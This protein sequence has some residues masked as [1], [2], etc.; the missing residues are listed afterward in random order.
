MAAN[1]R[2]MQVYAELAELEHRRG[3]LQ[4]RDRF[5]ILAADAALTDGRTDEAEKFRARLLEHNPH[6]LLR[7]YRSLADAM[8]SSDVYSY[9]ADLR[10]RY[11]PEEA[12]ALLARLSSGQEAEARAAVVPSLPA[13]SGNGPSELENLRLAREELK[14]EQKAP[15]SAPAP[16]EEA[17]LPEFYPLQRE[18]ESAAAPPRRPT[19][20]GR[21]PRLAVESKT[22]AEV[23]D[24]GEEQTAGIGAWIADGLFLLL[25]V[26][27]LALAVYTLGR[28]FLPLPDSPF[29]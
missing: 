12:E 8:K 27:G 21:P 26:A 5:L 23:V 1:D 10:A 24:E 15:T 2:K 17:N 28:P 11:P 3:A 19:A 9:I 25:L 20:V 4:E 22:A 14:E 6:H 29:K 18:P 7:P 13:E 16:Q